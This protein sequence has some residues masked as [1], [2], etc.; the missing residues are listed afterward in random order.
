MKQGNTTDGV[1]VCSTLT[2]IVLL[3][4]Y[5]IPYWLLIMLYVYTDVVRMYVVYT[6]GYAHTSDRWTDIYRGRRR[7]VI[8][9]SVSLGLGLPVSRSQSIPLSKTHRIRLVFLGF[10]RLVL[11]SCKD[12]DASKVDVKLQQEYE[13]ALL[14]LLSGC[15]Y[16]PFKICKDTQGIL[17][18]L[19]TLVVV[20]GRPVRCKDTLVG[21]REQRALSLQSQRDRVRPSLAKQTIV[22]PL[23]SQQLVES[24][25]AQV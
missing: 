16:S 22:I 17:G 13:L 23:S 2:P 8:S 7:S 11:K 12:T 25:V 9:V 18:D 24:V 10:R 21:E 20:R 19:R 5:S 15:S 6:P 3:C 4:T 1:Y 14:P